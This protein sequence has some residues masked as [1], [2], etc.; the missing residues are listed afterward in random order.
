MLVE[1]HGTSVP[2]AFRE[3]LR[4]Y[5]LGGKIDS[6]QMRRYVVPL[7]SVILNISQ[8]RNCSNVFVRSI[9]DSCD[10]LEA[11]QTAAP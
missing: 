2:D 3:A 8:I 6:V 9:T 11:S 10:L 5:R 4:V 7:M 1:K